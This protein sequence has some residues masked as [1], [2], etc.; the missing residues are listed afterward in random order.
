MLWVLIILFAAF[1]VIAMHLGFCL[2]AMKQEG[3]TV[4]DREYRCMHLRRR[5]VLLFRRQCT[6]AREHT[7][8]CQ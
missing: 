6:T 2:L 1:A 8:D 7:L 4:F 5:R 3:A